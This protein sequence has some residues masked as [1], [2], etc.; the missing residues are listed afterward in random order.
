MGVERGREKGAGQ[1]GSK[2]TG[3]SKKMHPTFD[4]NTTGIRGVAISHAEPGDAH[5]R[6]PSLPR[7]ESYPPGTAADKCRLTLP[8]ELLADNIVLALEQLLHGA[9]STEADISRDV[10]VILVIHCWDVGWWD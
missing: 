10:S 6:S 4:I 5:A 3:V 8:G 2:S 7:Q 1:E 9:V